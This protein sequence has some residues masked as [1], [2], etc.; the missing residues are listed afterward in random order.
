[1]PKYCTAPNCKNDSR[2]TGS[3][4]RSFYKY[5]LH[6]PERL[7]L[8]LKNMGRE[9]W[10]P[11]RHQYICHEHFLPSCFTLRWGIR[12]L[13]TDAVPTIFDL[14][15]S[16]KKRKVLGYLERKARRLRYQK[17]KLPPPDGVTPSKEVTPIRKHSAHESD[18]SAVQLY[19]VTFES[20]HGSEPVLLDASHSAGELETLPTAVLTDGVQGTE[21]DTPVNLLQTAKKTD[22]T[23]SEGQSEVVMM[24]ESPS[25]EGGEEVELSDSQETVTK[26][27]MRQALHD[28][29]SFATENEAT[30]MEET[31]VVQEE[32]SGTQLIAYFETIPNVLSNCASMQI[33]ASSETVLSS[34]LSSKP[35]VST[36]PIVSKHV[37]P[38]PDSLVLTLERLVS[39]EGQGE[40]SEGTAGGTK[41]LE[42]H[43]YHKN[44]L[45]KEQLEAIVIELQ[46]KVKVLQQRH[47]RHL[48]KL[49]GLESTVNQLRQSN[50]LKEE[51]LQLLERAY[52]QTSAADSHP[53]ETVAI[54]CEDENASHLHAEP[55]TEEEEG[56][57]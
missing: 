55:K 34:S 19:A 37:M 24:F 28:P 48:D 23:S 14:T 12:Y 3:G 47:R 49:L 9:E 52:L 1:M 57:G 15:E 22:D 54:I 2:D 27:G 44:N 31:S 25:L 11:T 32:D 41:Q 43:R 39:V 10:S 6:D 50:L 33:S 8:W 13:A 21:G 20:S 4:K 36:V 16:A 46:K 35:I 51:R 30:K 17:A 38:S 29:S 26:E 18:T 45:S 7:Q 42:E 53:G 40:E 5:P 56:L